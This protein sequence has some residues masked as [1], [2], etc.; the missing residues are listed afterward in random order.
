MQIIY[1]ESVELAFVYLKG[2]AKNTFTIYNVK[3]RCR[4]TIQI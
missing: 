4:L 3:D 1:K 2:L